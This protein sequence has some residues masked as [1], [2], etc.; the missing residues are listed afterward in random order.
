MLGYPQ[1]GIGYRATKTLLLVTELDSILAEQ[2][3]EGGTLL[4]PTHLVAFNIQL[5]RIRKNV[6]VLIAL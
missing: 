6:S 2:D 3:S 1:Q 4:D 5:W